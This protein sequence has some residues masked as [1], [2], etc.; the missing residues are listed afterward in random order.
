[1][2]LAS[3][4]GRTQPI[5][6]LQ[7]SPFFLYD[8]FMFYVVQYICKECDCL[9]AVQ[10]TVPLLQFYTCYTTFNH[11]TLFKKLVSREAPFFL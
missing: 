7:M 10:L 3:V 11:V 4:L 2:K 9:P 8:P 5:S 1:M 6:E